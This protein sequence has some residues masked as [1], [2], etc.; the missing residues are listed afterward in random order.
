MRTTWL[1]LVLCGG[2]LAASAATVTVDTS[3]RHQAIIGWGGTASKAEA[4]DAV[5][6]QVLDALVNDLGLTGQRLEPPGGNRPECRRWE[7]D[8]DDADPRHIRWEA[9]ATEALDRRVA[10][11]VAPFRKLVEARGEPYYL[12]VS[13][14]FFDGGSSGSAPPWLLNNPDE[15]AEYAIACLL[16]LKNKHGIVANAWSVCNEAGNNN[17]FNPQVMARMIRALGPRL[18]AEG[19]P[20]KIQFS[21]GVNSGVT[22]RYI[23]AVK[24]SP[25]VWKHIG[26]LSYHLYGDRTK[27]PLIRDLAR[28]RKLPT[29][30]T[31]FM[32]TRVDD[33]YDD[34][35]EGGVSYW[36]HY[37][38]C[39]HGNQ[40]HNGCYLAVRLDGTSFLRY[41]QYW[42]FRQ[43][44]HYVR[45][46][47]VRVEARCDG[48]P[49]RALA[50]LA[51]EKATAVLLNT[52]KGAQPQSVAVAALPQGSYGTC[53]AV[54]NR[55]YQEL[56]VRKVDASGRLDVDV[57]ADAVLTIYPHA[58]GNT[59]PTITLWEAAPSFL[60]LPAER[61]V[62]SAEATDAEGNKVAF[63]WSVTAQPVGADAKLASPA[64]AKT[65]VTG[66]NRAG[67]YVFD[68]TASDGTASS[69]RQVFLRVHAANEPPFIV[70]LHN[71]IP[72]E[73]T[74]A[75]GATLLRAGARDLEG[76][77]LTFLW[78]IVSQPA[79]AN[80]QL[81]TPDKSGCKVTGMT[82][83]GDYIFCFEAKDPT[84]A[85]QQRLTVPVGPR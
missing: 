36:E 66:L 39:G 10:A 27:R 72:V 50:F 73:P 35:T 6:D 55:P 28:E 46:G 52:A 1:G 25:D 12:Y 64:A 58:G 85:V 51:G 33:L 24:D 57:P 30:Q 81:D 37:V 15:Y 48:T 76:D 75:A 79:G 26:M 40:V 20:T 44:M 13:P 16:H 70:D 41:G 56:G 3:A 77:P 54:G 32:G 21:E 80:A 11:A 82:V 60:T 8:N 83:A 38:L 29:A 5:R 17:A 43:V 18:A 63:A 84:H 22:W 2:C 31:E 14:S 74:A 7:F 23:Q 9:F 45:P 42:K 49:L 68:V 78:S 47:A 61:S 62:L 34:L 71:R 69:R 59:P 53:R 19:L 67:D 65:E 4:P